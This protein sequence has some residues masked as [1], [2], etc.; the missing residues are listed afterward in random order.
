[1]QQLVEARAFVAALGAAD[2]LI[3]EYRDHGPAV[4]LGDGF[5]L[6]FLVL[7]GLMIG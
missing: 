7:Y 5:Q 3:L 1:L 6:A 4:P 2:T